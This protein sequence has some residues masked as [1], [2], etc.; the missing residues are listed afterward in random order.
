[1]EEIN[2]GYDVV[3]GDRL[4]FGAE[5]MPPL[6]KIGNILFA[7]VSSVF[8][9]TRVHDVTTGMRAYRREVLS[10]ITWTENTGLSAELLI[11]PIFRGY[12]VKEIPIKY[13]ARMGQTTL[14]PIGGGLA[15]FTSIIEVSLK[16]H[17]RQLKY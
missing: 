11:R 15:I 10:S 13:G 6:N 17:L 9:K 14:D 4:Y 5:Y 2:N 7:L 16:E 3:S 8:L 1:L 12:R